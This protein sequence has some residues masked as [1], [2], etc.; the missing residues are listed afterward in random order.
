VFNP[1]PLTPVF[2][3]IFSSCHHSAWLGFFALSLAPKP[4]HEHVSALDVDLDICSGF[5]GSGN[6]S[7]LL[8]SHLYALALCGLYA[9][10]HSSPSFITWTRFPLS[11]SPCLSKQQN[12]NSKQHQQQTHADHSRSASLRFFPF[13]HWH[14]L[15]DFVRPGCVFISEVRSNSKTPIASNTNSKH[16]RTTVAQRVCVFSPR[17]PLALAFGLCSTWLRIYFGSKV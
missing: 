9:F 14:S 13:V 7:A 3:P 8:F 12:T 2:F 5:S 15:L 11:L 10:R 6:C 17:C 16:M 1:D 4:D